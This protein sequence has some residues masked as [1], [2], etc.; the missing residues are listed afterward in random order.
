MM[1]SPVLPASAAFVLLVVAIGGG[2]SF[3]E[4][5]IAPPAN[6]IF[7]P[8]GLVADPDADFLYVVNSNSDLR[9]NAGTVVAVPALKPSD[10]EAIRALSTTQP[11]TKTR[12]SR[13]EAV[14]DNF[15]CVDMVDSNI[16]NC[17]EPQFVQSDATIQ[18]G[19]FGGAIQL[20]SYTRDNGEAVRRLFVAV[21]AEPS[22]TFADVTIADVANADGGTQK[23][24][25]MRCTGPKQNGPAQPIN[26]FCDDTWK[27][28]RHGGDTP[29]SFDLPEEPHVLAYDDGLKTLYV[30]HLTVVANSQIQG[31][32][33]S[34]L[35]VRDQRSETPVRFAGLTLNTFLPATLPQAVAALSMAPAALPV[36]PASSPAQVDCADPANPNPAPGIRVY[37]TARYSTAISGMVLRTPSAICDDPLQEPDALTLVPSES[38]Y[39]SAFLP[40]RG[41]DI[42]GILF[43]GTRAFVLHRNDADTSANPAA[44][45]V[46]D[47]HPLADGSP[48]NTPIDVL[49]VCGGP[50]AMEMWDAGRGKRIY[51]T[52]YDDGLIYVVDPNALVVT[53]VIDV[54]AGPTSLVFSQRN[55]G[56]AYVAS[57][58]NSHL[59]VIDL[60]PGSLTENHVVLRIGLPHGYGE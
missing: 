6:R 1:R 3:G 40:P 45:V 37:A 34:T 2:C 4:S 27:V 18:I 46:L 21:R 59:S 42:R 20:Q 43:D 16:I 49:E 13:T 57:F 28:R 41:A 14:P 31:G 55:P 7:L 56:V 25:S 29:G 36:A 9:F 53:S 30:G 19:S 17:N 26:P 8:A 47:R 5:G 10:A 23:V 22:I 33:V 12:F 38:F 60:A 54:G 11:C 39:S 24:V 50:T 51:V 32:G 35:D 15:C 52:C 48:A 44:L 58:A